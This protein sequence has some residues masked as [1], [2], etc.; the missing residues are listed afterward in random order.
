M[1]IRNTTR[2][3]QTFNLVC[4]KKGKCTSEDDCL[5]TSVE[6]QLFVELPDGTKGIRIVERR[7]PGSVTV[8]AKGSSE[9]LPAWIADS[10]EV[11]S[12][13]ARGTIRLVTQET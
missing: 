9:Q 2:Q 1:I 7:L 3:A 4:P 8:L 6:T 10:P 5:C 13:L 12:A 11:K